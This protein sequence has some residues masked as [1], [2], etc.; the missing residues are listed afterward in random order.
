M[1]VLICT[2]LTECRY[3]FVPRARY[4]FP[5]RHPVW[6][7]DEVASIPGVGQAEEGVVVDIVSV[8]IRIAEGGVDTWSEQVA[9]CSLAQLG[10]IVT[11]MT[12]GPWK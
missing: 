9:H 4:S 3:L 8:F 6:G 10:R 5:L 7:N 11:E 1:P 2:R 12:S